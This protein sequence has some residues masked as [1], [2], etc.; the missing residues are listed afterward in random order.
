MI[1]VFL[2]SFSTSRCFVLFE[3]IFLLIFCILVSKSAFVTESVY[4]NLAVKTPAAKLLN[5]GVVMYLS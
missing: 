4:T 2:N 5:S 3:L 1:L